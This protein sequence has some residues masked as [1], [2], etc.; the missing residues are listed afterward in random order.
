MGKKEEELA[1]NRQ[2]SRS[3]VCFI[4]EYE[5]ALSETMII[6]PKSSSDKRQYFKFFDSDEKVVVAHLRA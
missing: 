1:L 2:S 4:E 5:N 3:H 6:S